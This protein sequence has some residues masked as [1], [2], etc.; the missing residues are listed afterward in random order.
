[1]EVTAP[2]RKA[3]VLKIP[4]RSSSSLVR[5]SCGDRRLVRLGPHVSAAALSGIRRLACDIR[6]AKPA[7]QPDHPPGAGLSLGG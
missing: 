1:M 4:L 2:S 7:A 6:C 3:T 5:P